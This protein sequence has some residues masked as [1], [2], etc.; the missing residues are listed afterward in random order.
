MTSNFVTVE[1]LS[2][3]INTEN[4]IILDA[5]I[6][7]ATDNSIQ[8]NSKCIPNTIWFDLKKT[9]SKQDTIYPNTVPSQQNFQKEARLLGI[10]SESKIIIYDKHGVYSSPRVWWLFKLMRH[11]NVFVL[12]GGLPEWLNQNKL[13][14]D[15]Y[16]TPQPNG[17]FTANYQSNLFKDKTSVLEHSS[18]SN[19]V[20]IDARSNKRF[21]GLIEEPREGLRSGH[22]PNSKN[23]HYA[24]L[25]ENNK[26]LPKTDLET[27]FKPFNIKNKHIIYSCGSGITACILA[28]A[29]SEIGISNFSIY[30]GS[31]TEWGSIPE[32]PIER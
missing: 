5:T 21:L 16:K 31:W 30:D 28:I 1:W 9:F 8:L 7:K 25:T 32:L 4:L 27:N 23:L 15:N 20:I 19:T 6:P 11:E 14:S 13:I 3:N 26:L 2:S 22:I 29:G 10:N 17:N 12:N 18:N 24:I